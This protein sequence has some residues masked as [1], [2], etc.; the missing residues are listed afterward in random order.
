MADE[1][2]V[3]NPGMVADMPHLSFATTTRDREYP[4]LTAPDA[5]CLD[6]SH[7]R[8]AE[9]RDAVLQHGLRL[10]NQ[11]QEEMVAQGRRRRPANTTAHTALTAAVT[12]TT[13]TS[14]PS[15]A[16]HR[17]T[18]DP[19]I[20]MRHAGA[21]TSRIAGGVRKSGVHTG[22]ISTTIS[23][24]VK[25]SPGTPSGTLSRSRCSHACVSF[26]ACPNGCR[27]LKPKLPP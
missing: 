12:P 8:A 27:W 11:I 15:T 4:P 22:V 18:T 26:D 16:V 10:A 2:V 23:T 21:K 25:K 14:S 7:E 24:A 17:R 3:T 19:D 13:S 1:T 6:D 9:E 5:E 20:P